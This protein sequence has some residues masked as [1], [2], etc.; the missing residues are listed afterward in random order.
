MTSLR[1]TYPIRLV[2]VH[3]LT[4]I[5]VLLPNRPGAEV[6]G[7]QVVA[8]AYTA[9][10]QPCTFCSGVIHQITLQH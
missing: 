7:T 4:R 6:P 1:L 9:W 2:Q 10:S 8:K 5:L 3:W